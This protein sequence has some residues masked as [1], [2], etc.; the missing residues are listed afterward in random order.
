MP[1]KPKL[2][3][4][5]GPCRE[6]VRADRLRRMGLCPACHE[7]DLEV[8]RA[9]TAALADP[10]RTPYQPRAVRVLTG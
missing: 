7:A 1:R 4:C 2:V 8:R 5:K 6:K 10:P 9:I 3:R